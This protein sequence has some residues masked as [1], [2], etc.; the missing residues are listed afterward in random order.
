MKKKIIIGIL[1]V[2]SLII[3]IFALS[4]INLKINGISKNDINN[5][6]NPNL[7]TNAIMMNGETDQA[8][9]M[10]RSYI[11]IIP[12]VIIL[13]IS[14][15]YFRKIKKIEI[16]KKELIKGIMLGVIIGFLLGYFHELLHAISFPKGS[17][18]NIGLVLKPFYF[19]TSSFD[20][21]SKNQ[22]IFMSIIPFIIL[23]VIH[24]I[25]YLL[26][27]PKRIKIGAFFL[28]LCIMGLVGATPDLLNIYN[29]SKNVPNN[30]QII[31]SENH[32]YYYSK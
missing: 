21:F 26:Y 11:F 16:K 2:V 30:S 25:L 27:F 24:F 7:P 31:I 20:S 9:F 4:N 6:I 22:F 18:I 14:M 19:Y 13:A 5:V 23:G 3:F 15:V 10:T 32:I 29:V 8:T 17:T 28:G 1:I 12:I